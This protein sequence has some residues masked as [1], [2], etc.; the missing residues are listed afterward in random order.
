MVNLGARKVN[1][2]SCLQ[3]GSKLTQARYFTSVRQRYSLCFCI[4]SFRTKYIF[5]HSSSKYLLAK[6]YLLVCIVHSLSH[7]FFDSISRVFQLHNHNGFPY[8]FRRRNSQLYSTLRSLLLSTPC[9]LLIIF[10]FPSN[11]RNLILEVNLAERVQVL[12][13]SAYVNC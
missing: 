3:N 13:S 10:I 9:T 5:I 2:L 8:S 7:F 1:L 11:S 6:Q 12:L 4:A